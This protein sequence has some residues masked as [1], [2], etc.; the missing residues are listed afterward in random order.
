MITPTK[1]EY[2]LLIW[3]AKDDYSHFGECHG[4]TLDTCV[5]NYWA[6]INGMKVTITAKGFR[7]LEDLERRMET[8]YHSGN[9][10]S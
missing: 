1:D 2:D 10:T 5:L 9:P 3:L 7:L 4:P 8:P 6:N